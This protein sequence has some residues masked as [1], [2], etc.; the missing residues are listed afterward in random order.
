MAR[1]KIK[2]SPSTNKFRIESKQDGKFF[3]YTFALTV[4]QHKNKWC[5]FEFEGQQVSKIVMEETGEVLF[6][7][8]DVAQQRQAEKEA[9]ELDKQQK[10]AREAEA[11]A[12]EARMAYD[13][14]ALQKALIPKDTQGLPLHK[15]DNFAL[16]LNKLAHYDGKSFVFHQSDGNGT[17]S[18]LPHFGDFDFAGL[19]QRQAANAK[20]YFGEKQFQAQV[21]QPEWRTVVGLG[22]ASVYETSIT[23]H[24]VYGIPY[25]PGS[26]IKGVVRHWVIQE[27]FEESEEAALTGESA[28][29][30][31][32]QQWFGATNQQGQVVFWEA[33]PT[34]KPTIQVDIMNPHYSPYY[35]KQRAPADYYDP[36]PIPFLTVEKTAFQFVLGSKKQAI[37]N[38]T[39]AGKTLYEWLTE[40]LSMQGVGAKTAVGYGYYL[41]S[42]D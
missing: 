7:D 39:L 20:D 11:K 28:E 29:A 34:H 2:Y 3:L 4:E 8:A 30:K 18:I 42:T 17:K 36:I 23:L 38:E 6:P 33:F 25:I 40:A 15:P 10:A 31:T 19:A 13:T 9:L 24:H 1:G 16:K 22:E 27:V 41:K 12:Y 35:G 5:N 14:Y 26:A 32:F 21:F 37:L